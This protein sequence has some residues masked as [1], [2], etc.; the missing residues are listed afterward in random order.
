MGVDAPL[1]AICLCHLS[2]VAF[3]IQGSA[4]FGFVPAGVSDGRRVPAGC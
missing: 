2:A 1:I 3:K 4:V